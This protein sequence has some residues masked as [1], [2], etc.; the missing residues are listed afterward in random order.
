MR[1]SFA[2]AAAALLTLWV[3]NAAAD[4]ERMT[5]AEAVDA[6]NARAAAPN[7][8]F[9]G[10]DG[11]WQPFEGPAAWTVGRPNTAG[12]GC[13]IDV[14]VLG[15]A[16]AAQVTDVV[17]HITGDARIASVTGIVITTVTPTLAELQAFDAV[18]VFTNS[19]PQNNIL[20]GDNLADYVDSGGGVVLAMFALRAS[21]A[22]RT[23]EG[24]FGSD[25][26]YCIERSVGTTTT[27][28]ATLGAVYVPSSPLL[29]NVATFDGGTSSFRTPAPLNA[30]ATRIADWSTGQI[31][32]AH[33]TDL[34]ADRVDLGFFA[35]SQL[36]SG[37]SW[38]VST[39]GA[40]L[41]RNAVAVAAGCSGQGTTPGDLNCDGNV[42]NFDIDPF[43]L[44]VADAA[45]Y[46][47][48]FPNCNILNA[49]INNDGIV[50]NFDIDPFVALLAGG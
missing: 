4:E 20:L 34:A 49:D 19:T 1:T 44:A 24:R 3:A 29:H 22:T 13:F 21:L 18:L 6:L 16:V 40:A 47:V 2:M 26:Y 8:T 48:A 17:N 14:A 31:L 38:L 12:V 43:V 33:R 37:A 41:L 25:N 9:P 23:I 50:N 45:A 30:N 5:V 35:V 36:A 10:E 27:G 46:A 7:G 11:A 15:A 32:I 39:D 28:S 42:N